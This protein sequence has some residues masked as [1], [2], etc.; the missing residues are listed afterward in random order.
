MILDLDKGFSSKDEVDTYKKIISMDKY[1]FACFKSPSGLGLK[2]LVKIPFTTSNDV[3]NAHFEGISTYFEHF[4]TNN[5]GIVR[6]L[7]P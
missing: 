5:K 1:V 6:S 3:Y 2:V 7:F 4:D